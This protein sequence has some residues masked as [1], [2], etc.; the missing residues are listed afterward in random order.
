[1]AWHGT[2]W[3]H[4]PQDGDQSWAIV[5]KMI[6]LSVWYHCGQFLFEELLVF[7]ERLCSAKLVGWFV[8]WFLFTWRVNSHDSTWVRLVLQVVNFRS[9]PTSTNSRCSQYKTITSQISFCTTCRGKGREEMAQLVEVTCYKPWG[10]GFHSPWGYSD[11][12]LA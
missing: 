1:M 8:D 11:F 5:H 6:R 4:L 2:N 9:S 10:R 12:S 3:I 7:H